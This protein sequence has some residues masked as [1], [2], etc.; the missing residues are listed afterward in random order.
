MTTEN[1]QQYLSF[2]QNQERHNLRLMTDQLI[3]QAEL[4]FDEYL[5][6]H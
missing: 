3:N 5:S 4:L 2:L 6:F 1:Y